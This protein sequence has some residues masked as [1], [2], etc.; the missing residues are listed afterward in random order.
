MLLAAIESFM[1]ESDLHSAHYLFG[2]GFNVSNFFTAEKVSGTV[3]WF[4]VKSGYGFIN[5]LAN[6][7]TWYYLVLIIV[8]YYSK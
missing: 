1:V 4:N 5:R 2:Q 8:W 6:Q 7:T 3:K